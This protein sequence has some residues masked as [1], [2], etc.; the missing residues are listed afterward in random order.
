VTL[1]E[2]REE[3]ARARTLEGVKGLGVLAQLDEQFYVVA[4]VAR[5]S[6]SKLGPNIFGTT[7]VSCVGLEGLQRTPKIVCRNLAPARGTTDKRKSVQRFGYP[8]AAGGQ[9]LVH[10]EG[11]QEEFLGGSEVASISGEEAKILE[12]CRNSDAVRTNLPSHAKRPPCHFL[13]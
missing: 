11:P 10:T 9:L 5:I 13:R 2:H 7:E 8:D 4:V 6:H 3:R 1:G 12:T